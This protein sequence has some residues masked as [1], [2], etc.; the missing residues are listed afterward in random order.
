MYE[1]KVKAQKGQ[2]KSKDGAD[3][4]V[5]AVR[6]NACHPLVHLG[7]HKALFRTLDLIVDVGPLLNS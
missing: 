3:V 4:W 2:N 6:A 1:Y 7:G 5:H